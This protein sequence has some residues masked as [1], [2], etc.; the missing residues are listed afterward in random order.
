MH[1][2][3]NSEYLG[4]LHYLLTYISALFRSRIKKCRGVRDSKSKTYK[5]PHFVFSIDCNWFIYSFKFFKCHVSSVHT[6]PGH[7]IITT[8]DFWLLLHAVHSFKC[9]SWRKL[10]LVIWFGVFKAWTVLTGCPCRSYLA[11]VCSLKCPTSILRAGVSFTSP[12]VDL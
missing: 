3:N 5:C 2:I 8:F 6:L 4:R 12:T 7:I 9:S 1:Y 10:R 11:Y